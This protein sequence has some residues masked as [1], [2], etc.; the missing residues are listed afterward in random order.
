MIYSSTRHE[1]RGTVGAEY[2]ISTGRKT[3]QAAAPV[4]R[5]LLLRQSGQRYPERAPEDTARL[6]ALTRQLHH[7]LPK[8]PACTHL[9]GN[10]GLKGA[11]RAMQ[12]TIPRATSDPA[13]AYLNPRP[14]ITSHKDITMRLEAYTSRFEAWANGGVQRCTIN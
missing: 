10:G 11:I 3:R 14:Q 6:A 4:L 5:P 13:R 1:A 9:R 8:S 7:I 2:N 12:A